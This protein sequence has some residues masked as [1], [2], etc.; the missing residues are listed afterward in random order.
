MAMTAPLL[1]T[2][3]SGSI[4]VREH[5]RRSDLTILRNG[6]P[7]TF[8][9]LGDVHISL[10]TD[11]IVTS[12]ERAQEVSIGFGG[13]RFTGMHDGRLTF[14]RVRDLRPEEELSPDRSWTMTLEPLW[15]AAIFED[16][17]QVWPTALSVR[18]AGLCASCIHAKAIT[19]SRG[20][21]FSL[22]Q[23]SATDPGFPRYPVL[24]VRACRGYE[25]L[26]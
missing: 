14:E 19:S 25:P 22:C 16:G 1:I 24:P 13:M 10:P 21:A 8:V 12:E 6:P 26:E 17:R 7:G 2:F 11:Q 5:D 18:S 4:L 15:V 3:A 9:R 20:S 23:R